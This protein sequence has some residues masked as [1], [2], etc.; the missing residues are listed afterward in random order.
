MIVEKPKHGEI[1]EVCYNCMGSSMCAQAKYDTR[2]EA[3]LWP[4]YTVGVKVLSW[5]R[6][7]EK[8][9]RR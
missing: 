1:I 6:Y 8:E 5:R 3:Y 9:W 7:G 4:N 2:D